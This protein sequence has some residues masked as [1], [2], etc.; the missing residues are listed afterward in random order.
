[1]TKPT[2]PAR[3]M[4]RKITQV[5]TTCLWSRQEFGRMLAQAG[6]A[7]SAAWRLETKGT[8]T[9]TELGVLGKILTARVV[10]SRLGSRLGDCGS[11]CPCFGGCRV[12]RV[13]DLHTKSIF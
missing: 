6:I 8:V 3:E 1:M 7:K 5:R 4:A 10:E 12:L 2:D 13:L 11:R 9:A